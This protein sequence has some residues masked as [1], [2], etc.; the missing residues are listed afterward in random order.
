MCYGVPHCTCNI[1]KY[2]FVHCGRSQGLLMSDG[3]CYFHCNCCKHE[4]KT[5]IWKCKSSKATVTLN[6]SEFFFFFFR[7]K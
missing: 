6:G 7:L 3:I 2:T 1:S 4:I 5:E